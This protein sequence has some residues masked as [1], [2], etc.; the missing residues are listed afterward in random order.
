MGNELSFID[1]KEVTNIIEKKISD[2]CIYETED[3]ES[4]FQEW[5]INGDCFDIYYLS[6]SIDILIEDNMKNDFESKTKL[7]LE[8][9]N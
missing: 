2:N 3:N 5:K 7:R 4:A 1:Y 9:I 8:E 6:K